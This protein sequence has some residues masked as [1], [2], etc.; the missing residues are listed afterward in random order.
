MELRSCSVENLGMSY[1]KRV[2]K[3]FGYGDNG[4]R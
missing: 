2:K 1:L 3:H 4:L